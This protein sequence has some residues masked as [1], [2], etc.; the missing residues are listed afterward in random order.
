MLQQV[1]ETIMWPF[2]IFGINCQAV[3]QSL[4]RQELL[5]KEI[6]MNQDE[7][8]VQLSLSKSLNAQLIAL[9]QSLQTA[10][11][12]A[13][14]HNVTPEVESAITDLIAAQKAAL[15]PAPEA[16]TA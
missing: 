15:P 10:I 6:L 2:N 5:L 7:L 4:I 1:N 14:T 12:N 8:L 13:N 11:E 16:P 3:N 9:I